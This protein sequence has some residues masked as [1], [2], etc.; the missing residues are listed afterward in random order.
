MNKQIIFGVAA[1]ALAGLVACSPSNDTATTDTTTPAT[2]EATPLPPVVDP[3]SRTAD[4]A[5]AVFYGNTLEIETSKVAQ[6]KSRNAD[7]KAFAAMIIRDHTAAQAKLKTW[8][9]AGAVTLPTALDG[10]NQM[11]LDNI[12][13]A[14]A[15]GFDDKY[16]DTVIDAHESAIGKFESYASDGADPA[17]KQTATEL[18]PT[19]RAHFDRAKAIRDAVNKS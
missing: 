6:A 9:T 2:T 19:L 3:A 15:T 1:A 17:L 7:V 11:L 12:A 13:N 16:L 10:P 18:L 4:F 8:A 5:N 14:D